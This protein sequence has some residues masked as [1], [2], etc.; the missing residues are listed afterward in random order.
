MNRI[1]DWLATLWARWGRLFV[2][3]ACIAGLFVMA[4]MMARM[5]R[6]VG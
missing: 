1:G 6:A 5:W 3:C 2:L 4:L